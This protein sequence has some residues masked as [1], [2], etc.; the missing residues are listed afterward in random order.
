M[1]LFAPPFEADYRTSLSVVGRALVERW[2]NRYGYA[3]TER[4]AD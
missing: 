1:D 2:L 3:A 4:A